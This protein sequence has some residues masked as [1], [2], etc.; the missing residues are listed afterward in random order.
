MNTRTNRYDS[1]YKSTTSSRDKFNKKDE[2][3]VFVPRHIAQ[4]FL[5]IKG[6][7]E[8]KPYMNTPQQLAVILLVNQT[9]NH[10]LH[11]RILQVEYDIKEALKSRRQKFEASISW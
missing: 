1:R 6:V 4:Q 5:A 7:K 2:R 10:T 9:Y 3:P 8:V 11:S